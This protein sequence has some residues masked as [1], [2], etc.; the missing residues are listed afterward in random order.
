[1]SGNAFR[2]Y[3]TLALAREAF[4]L[5]EMNGTVR[6]VPDDVVPARADVPEPQPQTDNAAEPELPGLVP[7]EAEEEECDCQCCQRRRDA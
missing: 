3:A 6:I 5:A 2:R 7:M 4:E 1:M